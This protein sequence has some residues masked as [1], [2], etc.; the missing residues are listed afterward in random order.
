MLRVW[1]IGEL[2]KSPPSSSNKRAKQKRR[3][4]WVLLKSPDCKI[5]NP[6]RKLSEILIFSPAVKDRWVNLHPLIRCQQEILSQVY[7]WWRQLINKPGV[8]GEGESR[9]TCVSVPSSRRLPTSHFQL[10]LLL[11]R[12]RLFVRARAHAVQ[13]IE[14]TAFGNQLLALVIWLM[15]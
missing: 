15:D 6:K 13:Q 9:I 14:D 1:K 8:K 7:L 12:S 4:F 2:V 3:N 10:K 5:Q 11:S